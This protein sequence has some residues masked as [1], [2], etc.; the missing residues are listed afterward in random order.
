MKICKLSPCKFKYHS[1]I[2]HLSSLIHI[3]SISLQ[4]AFV[5]YKD[6][7][8]FLSIFDTF[9]LFTISSYRRKNKLSTY[10]YYL[11]LR[12]WIN[13]LPMSSKLLALFTAKTKR[14]P[15]PVLMY[16]SRIAEYSSWPAV[17]RMSNKQV[18]PSAEEK[19]M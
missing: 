3:N 19:K 12:I 1:P 7:G 18:S 6:H 15:S 4:I 17:S 2:T 8:Y 10:Y 14:K 5:A 9:D 13:V 11:V 16:W